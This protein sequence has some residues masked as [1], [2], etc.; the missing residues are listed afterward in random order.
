M[1][2][3]YGDIVKKGYRTRMTILITG[4]A[5]FIGGALT[6]ALLARGESIVGIDTL[7]GYYDPVLKQA[8]LARLLGMATPGDM[9]RFHAIDV[10]DGAAISDVARQFGPFDT[11]VHLAAQAGVRHSLTDP[12]G[13]TKA[14]IVGY[15][16]LLE[17]ARQQAES[18][19]RPPHLVYASSSSVYGGLNQPVC[20]VGDPVDRP[21]S[22]YAA[23]KRANELMSET[24]SHLFAIPLTGLRYFTVYGPWGRPDMAAILFTRNI[25]ADRPITLFNQGVHSR[26]FTYIDDIVA[27]TLAV[28]NNRPA[29]TENRIFNLGNDR[30]ET[31]LDLVRLIENSTDRTAVIEYAGLQPGDIISSCADISSAR[32][33]LGFAPKVGI[34]EGLPLL[35]DWVRSWYEGRY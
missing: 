4:C 29:N 11:I 30:S 24:Y 27:G 10:A 23:T 15:L 14:N 26:S 17:L 1:G 6:E 2:I 19:D 9:L 32:Q 35:V 22:L 3:A 13:V 25:L 8:R 12:F 7:N 28:I 20:A 5:G 33:V 21:I 18:G 16:S 31:L 34:A